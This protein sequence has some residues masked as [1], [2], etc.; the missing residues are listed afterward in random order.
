MIRPA[1]DADRPALAAFLSRY[2]ETSMFLRQALARYGVAGG[3][4]RH[5]AR[6]WV[7]HG[8]DGALRGCVALTMQGMLLVQ[9][10]GP[11]PD[12]LRAVQRVIAGAET[13]GITGDAGQVAAL[14][15]FLWPDAPAPRLDR[16][17]PLYRL[18]LARLVMPPAAGG[19]R[20]AAA[21]DMSWLAEWRRAYNAETLGAAPDAI[22]EARAQVQ[23]LAAE[24]RL[25]VLDVGASPV[26]MTSFNAA[27]PDI[28]QIGGVYTPPECRARGHARAAVALHLAEARAA[29]V[30]TAI[31]FAS[32]PPAMRAY[33]AI[34]FERIGAYA[35]L[36]F[37]ALIRIPVPSEGAR[38]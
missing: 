34:G 7:L 15:P 30:A 38:S 28:V 33:E 6:F 3:P 1:V 10:P 25:R 24:D 22:D 13:L 20:P 17:E 32:G 2:P 27:L 4:D 31:L 36:M 5:A 12:D 37:T 19:L 18:D 16:P 26:A 8:H 35:L 9:I 23:A 21:A 14:R 29:G 11:A